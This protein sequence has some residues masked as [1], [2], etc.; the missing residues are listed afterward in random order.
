[1]AN[2]YESVSRTLRPYYYL[3]TIGTLCIVFGVASWFIYMRYTKKTRD[4]EKNADIYNGTTQPPMTLYLFYADWCPAC[5]RAKPEWNNFRDTYNGRL[6]NGY[7][8][9]CTEIECSDESGT[10]ADL[11]NRYNITQF[12]TIKLIKGDDIYDFDAKVTKDHLEKFVHSV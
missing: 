12:P 1:M 6:I 4:I 8:L 2:L 11:V 9:T 5:K 3:I 10:T 7:K